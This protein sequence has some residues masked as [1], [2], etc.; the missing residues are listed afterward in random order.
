MSSELDKDREV[1]AATTPGPWKHD[2]DSE[3][4]QLG[5]VTIWAGED[6]V[7][8]QVIDDGRDGYIGNMDNDVSPHANAAFIARARTRYPE[9][10]EEVE[11][12][13]GQNRAVA[14]M[15]RTLA[16]DHDRDTALTPPTYTASTLRRIA[17]AIDD[18][19][20]AEND[21]ID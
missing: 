15:L 8:S 12:L 21:S 6:C 5:D 16:D 1:I 3:L 7:V 9:L 13:R 14:R 18:A 19:Y 2:G 4:G 10:V 17:D 11:R 20:E